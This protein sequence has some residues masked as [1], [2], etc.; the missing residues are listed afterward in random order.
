MMLV[1]FAVTIL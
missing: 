1:Y